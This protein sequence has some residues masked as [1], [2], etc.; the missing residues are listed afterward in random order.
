MPY[1]KIQCENLDAFAGV[2]IEGVEFAGLVKNVTDGYYTMSAELI[3]LKRQISSLER[4]LRGAH[5]E[6]SAKVSFS[7]RVVFHST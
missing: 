5:K 4:R 6:V 7:V 3:R 2:E 1:V